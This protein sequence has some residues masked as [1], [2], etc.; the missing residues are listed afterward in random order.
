MRN[1]DKSTL[2]KYLFFFWLLQGRRIYVGNVPVPIIAV[3][4]SNYYKYSKILG[5]KLA[6]LTRESFDYDDL[7]VVKCPFLTSFVRMYSQDVS[8]N[9]VWDSPS[10]IGPMD[11]KFL[12]YLLRISLVSL[13]GGEVKYACFSKSPII[14]NLLLKLGI[15]FIEGSDFY[16]ISEAEYSKLTEYE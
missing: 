3:H 12:E 16:K 6:C 1:F 10:T 15:D 5:I 13:C 11:K 14:K 4:I 9:N 7:V 8:E 2:E